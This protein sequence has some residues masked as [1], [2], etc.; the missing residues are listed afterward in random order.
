MPEFS[1][2]VFTT[3]CISFFPEGGNLVEGLMNTIAFKAT[4]EK[5]IPVAVR[6]TISNNKN[7]KITSFSSYHDGMGMFELIPQA[8]LNY[9]A[10]F[11]ADVTAKN[12]LCPI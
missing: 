7:E 3:P 1:F 4:D 8:G 12:I 5:G 6:G 10:S 2:S 9:F 11:E